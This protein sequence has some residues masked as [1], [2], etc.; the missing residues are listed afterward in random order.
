MIVSMVIIKYML[1][2]TFKTILQG[3]P[4]ITQQLCS[5]GKYF[6]NNKLK[7]LQIM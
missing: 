5:W 1:L 3:H 7:L 6:L 4:F 2:T